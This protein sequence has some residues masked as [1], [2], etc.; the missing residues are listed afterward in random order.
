MPVRA[1]QIP[2]GPHTG[3]MW[4]PRDMENIEASRVGPAIYVTKQ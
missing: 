4:N 1:M 3:P 2:S